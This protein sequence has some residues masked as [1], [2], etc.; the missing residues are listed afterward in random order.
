LCSSFVELRVNAILRVIFW[1]AAKQQPADLD[2][3][4]KPGIHIGKNVEL[5]MIL[6][7]YRRVPFAEP[8]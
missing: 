3:P 1:D 4:L 8:T 2:V 7:L 5:R 6:C